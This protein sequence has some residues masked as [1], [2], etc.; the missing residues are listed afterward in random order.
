ME[1]SQFHDGIITFKSGLIITVFFQNDKLQSLVVEL[2]YCLMF[3]VNSL[4]IT[5]LNAIT[6]ILFIFHFSMACGMDQ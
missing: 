4:Y 5:V 1:L 6:V 2:L 3:L